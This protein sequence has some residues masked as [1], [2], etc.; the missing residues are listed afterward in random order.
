MICREGYVDRQAAMDFAVS[1]II[2]FGRFLTEIFTIYDWPST[3]VQ[4]IRSGHLFCELLMQDF[5]GALTQ[6]KAI[7]GKSKMLFCRQATEPV[8]R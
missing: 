1:T 5:N 4:A 6:Q 8:H 3:L 2:V 7:D